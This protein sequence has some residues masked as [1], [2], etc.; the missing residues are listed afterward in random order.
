MW[1]WWVGNIVFVAV[2]IPVVIMILNM[3]IAPA[4]QIVG[5]ADDIRESV[6]LFPPHLDALQELATT[7]QLV[8]EAN[9]YLER[10]VRAL[11]Q[12]P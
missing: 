4:K 9:V 10:Y 8:K 11:D 12:I 3:V 1:L 2:I 5:Y 6:E 7:R